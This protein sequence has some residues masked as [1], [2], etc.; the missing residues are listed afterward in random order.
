MIAHT[1]RFLSGVNSTLGLYKE[2][3][4]QAREALEIYEQSNDKSGQGY[5]WQQLAW[6]L[7]KDNQLDAAEEAAS[8]GIDLLSDL[9]DQFSVCECYHTLGLIYHSRGKKG[10][11]INHYETALRI[12]TTFN[13]HEK[14][15]WIHYAMAQVF[16]DENRFIDAHVH[17]KHAKS[18]AINVTYFL[19]HATKL[20]AM[21]WYRQH[22]LKEAK[23]GA[24]D[25]VNVF[26]KLGAM[27]DLKACKELLQRIEWAMNEA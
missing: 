19:A 16:D 7:C 22:R 1:L 23:S 11:A 4:H 21:F 3:I 17:I 25:A 15:F 6:L 2:G 8:H 26:E 13:W 14:L 20:Q 24:L 10:E 5:A 9:H 18:H 27:M 12:A